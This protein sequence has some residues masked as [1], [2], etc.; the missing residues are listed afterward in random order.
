MECSDEPTNASK[1]PNIVSNSDIFSTKVPKPVQPQHGYFSFFKSFISVERESICKDRE[2]I[3]LACLD[4]L[5][6]YEVLDLL[7]K[8]KQINDSSV[9]DVVV[10]IEFDL[11]VN[12]MLFFI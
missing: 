5:S 12:C 2:G 10:A 9:K 4:G 6:D 1:D 3:V 8:M 7:I 11:V